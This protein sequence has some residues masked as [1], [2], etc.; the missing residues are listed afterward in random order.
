MKMNRTSILLTLALACACGCIQLKTE[1]EVKPIH[2]TMDVNL[3]I[4]KSLDKAFSDESVERPQG[5]FT[6]VKAMLDRQA[7]GV[8]KDAMLEAR[9]NA[10]DADRLLIAESNMS[11]LK[12]F[13]EIAQ[14]TG[15]T[16]AA[17]QKQYA[18]K[19]ASKIPVG[20]GVWVQSQDGA[21]RQ[22]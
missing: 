10:T 9:A 5:S 21:W 7:A 16:L 4:D 14:Q 15:S 8:T 1:S 17:V 20:S 18:E 22:K 2:I 11:H 12:R 6:Q 19:M 3:K 13:S